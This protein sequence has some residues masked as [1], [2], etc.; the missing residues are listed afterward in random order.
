MDSRGH[1]GC[2]QNDRR[3]DGQLP[4]NHPLS[5]FIQRASGEESL[6]SFCFDCAIEAGLELMMMMMM[7]FV[8]GMMMMMT[9]ITRRGEGQGRTKNDDDD[10]D[11]HYSKG[12]RPREDEEGEESYEKR[13]QWPGRGG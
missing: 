12:R 13:R 6:S 5:A 8:R 7:K 4:R 3:V 11:V 10:D 2:T 9:F 1:P